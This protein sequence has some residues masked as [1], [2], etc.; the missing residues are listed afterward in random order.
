MHLQHVNH[1]KPF[2]ST[3]ISEQLFARGLCLP[4]GSNLADEDLNRVID[5][6]KNMLSRDLVKKKIENF[7]EEVTSKRIEE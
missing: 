4:S 1:D 7:R 2:Y 6:I 3:G 5:V